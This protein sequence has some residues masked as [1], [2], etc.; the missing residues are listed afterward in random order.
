MLTDDQWE[1]LQERWPA[2]DQETNRLG[3]IVFARSD[4]RCI[5]EVG[6]GVSQIYGL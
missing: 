3:G 6:E 5:D 1:G 4:A 2:H